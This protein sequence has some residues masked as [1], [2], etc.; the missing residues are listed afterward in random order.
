MHLE[1]LNSLS[2]KQSIARYFFIHITIQIRYF[3]KSVSRYDT[4]CADRPETGP[5]IFDTTY[6]TFGR[7]LNFNMVNFS[8]IKIP[9][10]VCTAYRSFASPRQIELEAAD[11]KAVPYKSSTV[12]TIL[13]PPIL[14]VQ[15]IESIWFRR[16]E[17]LKKVSTSTVSF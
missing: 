17:T 10:D 11:D 2:N 1:V 3:L 12:P 13:G 8:V 9:D 16:Y 6:N 15:S 5:M 14:H 4:F 7:Q